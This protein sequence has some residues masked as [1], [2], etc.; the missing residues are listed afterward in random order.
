M[1]GGRCPRSVV[2]GDAIRFGYDDS[3]VRGIELVVPC[4]LLDF[5]G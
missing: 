2:G 3:V 1:Q 4:V 5:L